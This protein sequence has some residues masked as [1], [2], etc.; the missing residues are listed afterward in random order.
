MAKFIISRPGFLTIKSTLDER[1]EFT[2]HDTG[3]VYLSKN[4]LV[5]N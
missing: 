3:N 2:F 5:Y 1:L 4:L